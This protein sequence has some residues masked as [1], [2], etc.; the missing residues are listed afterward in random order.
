LT[1]RFNGSEFELNWDK[2]RDRCIFR[3]AG[4]FVETNAATHEIISALTTGTETAVMD[5]RYYHAMSALLKGI[6]NT[7]RVN[8]LNIEA[9][10]S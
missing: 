4:A 3:S 5:M 10:L 2:A 6:L 9:H 8:F 7:N 1:G